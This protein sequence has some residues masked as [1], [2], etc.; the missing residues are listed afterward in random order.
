MSPLAKYLRTYAITVILSLLAVISFNVLIDPYR[1]F[2]LRV[3][4]TINDVKPYASDKQKFG[5]ALLA[6]SSSADAAILGNSRAE[7]GFDPNYSGWP[8]KPVLNLAIAGTGIED[9]RNYLK[10]LA[11]FRKPGLV[12]LGVDF[13]DFLIPTDQT[14][15]VRS[16]STPLTEDYILSVYPDGRLYSEYSLRKFQN[17]V[18]DTVSLNTLWNAA[19]TITAQR[20][21]YAKNLTSNG[22]NPLK[23]YLK[24]AATEG[25]YALFQQ[26]AVEFS[27]TM[28][29]K[30][31][32]LY[33]WHQNTSSAFEIYRDILK[34][35][36]D[37]GIKL[38][39]LIYPYHAFN[40]EILDMAGLGSLYLEWERQLVKI[41]REETNEAVPLW[42]FS[43]YNRFTTEAVPD[44]GD[45]KTQL[46]WYWEAG[47]F[48]KELGNIV[49]ARVFGSP[50][51]GIPDSE[52]FGVL[53]NEANIDNHLAEF[54]RSR[55][56]YR[57]TDKRGMEIVR[58]WVG[59]H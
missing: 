30:P 35:C 46:Q 43:G 37:N 23:D 21:P 42:D 5:K 40:L 4:K 13:Q 16:E 34:Y 17:R 2:D 22:F 3:L 33:A 47:H 39:V 48:K 1:I 55:L 24:V 59:K 9:S 15:V 56:L 29:K 31:K 45:K 7:I 41:N 54:S 28:N 44:R 27:A 26:R 25:Y 50:I 58:Q 8:V 10:H 53:I 52:S 38:I 32:N 57:E 14:E 18:H 51:S 12:L 11:H 6:E 20:D 36:K 49:Q 19:G